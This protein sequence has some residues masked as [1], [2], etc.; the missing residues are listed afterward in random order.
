MSNQVCTADVS[1]PLPANTSTSLNGSAIYTNTFTFDTTHTGATP[2]AA[3]ASWVAYLGTLG[4]TIPVGFL[5]SLADPSSPAVKLNETPIQWG[6][7]SQIGLSNAYSLPY[8][9]SS[10][11]S[12][13]PVTEWVFITSFNYAVPANNNNVKVGYIANVYGASAK[14][15]KKIYFYPNLAN[16]PITSAA[17]LMNFVQTIVIGT[18]SYKFDCLNTTLFV[19]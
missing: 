17:A 3:F 9:T 8:N 19:K 15:W 12:L 16:N 1:N 6:A 10:P 4:I 14:A 7:H 5:N 13:D 2:A 18:N 11:V